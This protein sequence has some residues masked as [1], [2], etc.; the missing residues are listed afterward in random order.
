MAIRVRNDTLSPTGKMSFQQWFSTV[1]VAVGAVKEPI[2]FSTVNK[3]NSG[4]G[5]RFF[6]VVS[7]LWLL[8]FCFFFHPSPR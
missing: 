5:Y 3:N 1:D 6:S 7:M 8:V 4:T 2:G